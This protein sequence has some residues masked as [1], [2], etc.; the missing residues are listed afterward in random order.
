MSTAVKIFKCEK[1]SV[2]VYP[3][4]GKMGVAAAKAAAAKIRN[5]IRQKGEANLIFAAAPS[6]NEML[7]ALVAEDVDWSRVRGFHQD[8]YIG[9]PAGH[10]AL[11]AGYLKQHIFDRVPFKEVYYIGTSTLENAEQR[12]ADY[13]RLLKKYPPD[14]IFLGIG[15]NGHLAFNDPPVAD[16]H[17]PKMVK[18]VEL[19]LACRQQQVNDGCFGTLYDVPTH[20]I[21]LTIPLIRSVPEAIITVPSAR[22]AAA[23]KNALTGLIDTSCPASILRRHKSAALYLDKDSASKLENVEV[24]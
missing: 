5:I 13:E 21:T 8:E 19:D 7:D 12:C 14:L 16:F 10:P 23:V 20:A 2:Y 22:K 17:D 11:F 24:I 4:R 3:T 15:E 1:L 6:Q 9:L 18:V